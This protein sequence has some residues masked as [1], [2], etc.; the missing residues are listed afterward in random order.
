MV[1]KEFTLCGQRI[2]NRIV[3]QPMEGFDCKQNGEP[4]SYTVRKYLRLAEGGAAILWFEAN[5]VCEEGRTNLRQMYLTKENADVFRRLLEQVR[6]TAVKSCG[7][8]P[9]L[10]LQLTHSGRQSYHPTVMYKNEVYEA[11]GR[12]GEI[13]ADAYLD[14]LPEKFEASARLAEKVG[15]DGVDVKACHGYLMSESLSAFKREGRY[16]GSFENRTRLFLGCIEAAK[17][18]VSGNVILAS[19]FGLSDMVAYPNGFATDE[20]GNADLTETLRLI[21]QMRKRGIE[22][23]NITVGNPYYNPHVNRPYKKGAYI[24]PETPDVGLSR[25]HD[26][27]AVVRA[28]NPTLPI[29]GSGFTYYGKDMMAKA[30]EALSEGICDFVGFG[31]QILA[32]PTFYRDHLAGGIDPKKLCLTCSRCTEL[33]RAGCYAGCAIM[34]EPYR[35][36]YKENV[37]C[38]KQHL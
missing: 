2:A 17:S 22:L 7:Y 1:N 8:A 31:R 4:D 27:T 36:L 19:R 16:G 24:P 14:A 11:R 21:E 34:D 10:F 9:K 18:A 33:M 32:Y 38:K 35:N 25:F 26:L 3:F 20:N 13:L 15:F 28:A 29:V 12:G 6:E 5:A 37:T 23:L 30:N